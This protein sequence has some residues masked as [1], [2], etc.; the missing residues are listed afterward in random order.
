MA[1]RNK[2]DYFTQYRSS[3]LNI[4]LNLQESDRIMIPISIND[5]NWISW[6]N[7]YLEIR[8]DQGRISNKSTIIIN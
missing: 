8:E 5:E 1:Y 7:K 4:K 2:S 3:F 6:Q